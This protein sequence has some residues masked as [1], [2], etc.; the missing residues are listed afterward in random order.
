MVSWS[1]FR[2]LGDSVAVVDNADDQHCDNDSDD[3]G[4]PYGRTQIDTAM[5]YTTQLTIN[6]SLQ[7]MACGNVK[8]AKNNCEN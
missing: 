8:S 1:C 2:T 7:T 6:C 3:S 5:S 4:Q